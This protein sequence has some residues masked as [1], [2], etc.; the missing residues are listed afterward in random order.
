MTAPTH[1]QP[2][3]AQLLARKRNWMK[4]QLVGHLAQ[5]K[6]M[7]QEILSSSYEEFVAMLSLQAVYAQLL[8]DWDETTK[9]LLA[10]AKANQQLPK[11]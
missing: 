7:Q 5:T 2:T 9:A 4:R 3:P 6:N 1:K 8:A 10:A 11:K